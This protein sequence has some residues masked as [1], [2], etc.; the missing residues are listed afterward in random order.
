MLLYFFL[1]LVGLERRV[2]IIVMVAVNLVHI[3]QRCFC[4][5][6]YFTYGRENEVEGLEPSVRGV[7]DKG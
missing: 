6:E 3:L 2:G 5:D 1:F 7:G 4:L